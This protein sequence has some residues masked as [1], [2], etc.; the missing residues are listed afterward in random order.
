MVIRRVL[1]PTDAEAGARALRAEA[2]VR[3]TEV[4]PSAPPSFAAAFRRVLER[5]SPAAVERAASQHAGRLSW[6]LL[7]LV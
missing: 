3:A 6:A 7:A 5:V 4:D 2:L 1:V